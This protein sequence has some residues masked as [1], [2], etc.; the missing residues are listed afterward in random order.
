[1]GE[2]PANNSKSDLMVIG[3]NHGISIALAIGLLTV[4]FWLGT[5]LNNIQRDIEQIKQELSKAGSDRWTKAMQI[6]WADKF[7][8][9]NPALLIPD[10]RQPSRVLSGD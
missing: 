8:S 7:H 5:T 3:K 4:A 2:A 1:M 9:R 10:P 6:E